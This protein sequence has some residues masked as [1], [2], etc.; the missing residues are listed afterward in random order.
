MMKPK[1]ANQILLYS[2]GTLIL[3]HLSILTQLVPYE[4]VWGGKLK[5]DSE[6]YVFETVSIIINIFLGFLLLI[7]GSYI[8]DFINVKVVNKFLWAFLI[9]FC[10]NTIGNLVSEALFEKS[11]AILTLLFTFLIFIILRGTKKQGQNS[12]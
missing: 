12:T 10:L 11:L 7:K 9:L 1:L 5:K 8:P 6:M 2:I 4:F 3:F